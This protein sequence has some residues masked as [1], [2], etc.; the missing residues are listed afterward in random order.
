MKEE[1]VDKNK[2]VKEVLLRIVKLN[3]GLFLYAVGIVMAIEAEL[4]LGPWDVFHQGLANIMGITIGQA[5]IIVGFVLVVANSFF[6]ERLGWGTITNMIFI[7][8]YIDLLMFLEAIPVF[9]SFLPSLIMML[10]GLFVIGVA[11]YFYIGAGFGTGPRDGLMVV[12]RKRTN[13]SVRFIRNSIEVT[14]SVIGYLLGGTV[15]LGTVV[16]AFSIGYFVQFAFKL[17]KFDI[18]AVEHR[19]IDQDLAYL[20]KIL[21]NKKNDAHHTL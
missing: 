13:K 7:G 5:S 10:S 21:K 11:S 9:S 8:L 20:K 1:I 15:G 2:V 16:I 12:L 18:S 19:F 6:G 17:F 14:A 4:G 3:I